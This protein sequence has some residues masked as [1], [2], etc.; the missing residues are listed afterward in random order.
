MQKKYNHSANKFNHKYDKYI[1]IVCGV[2]C[3]FPI[4]FF[5]EEY[6]RDNDFFMFLINVS[7]TVF[8]NIENISK[9]GL[10]TGIYF[11]NKMQITFS[12]FAVLLKL[13]F[14]LYKYI[15]LYL[16]SLGVLKLN[17]TF[18]NNGISNDKTNEDSIEYL[19]LSFGIAIVMTDIYLTG[20]LFSFDFNNNF[21][22]FKRSKTQITE[23]S[24]INLNILE[25]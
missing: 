13:S 16:T 17:S 14:E 12:L 10:D 2:I 9:L 6:I 1:N 21:S 20:I 3:I 4:L 25:N 8:P 24:T 15:K 11:F 23:K 22:Y 19:L 7:T 5:N 18:F